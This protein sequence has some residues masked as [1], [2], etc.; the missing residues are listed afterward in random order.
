MSALKPATRSLILAAQMSSRAATR[1]MLAL[2]PPLVVVKLA[3]LLVDRAPR[4]I[5]LSLR[6][7]TLD[8]SP[9]TLL[10]ILLSLVE[11]P[12][13]LLAHVPRP[14]CRVL[15]LFVNVA[16]LLPSPPMLSPRVGIPLPNRRALL[17]KAVVFPRSPVVLALIR[18]VLLVSPVAL[19]PNIDRLSIRLPSFPVS[20]LAFIPR[21][22]AVADSRRALP[23]MELVLL[24]S[25]RKLLP[26]TLSV[27]GM[28]QSPLARAVATLPPIVLPMALPTAGTTLSLKTREVKQPCPRPV[29]HRTRVRRPPA[30][31]EVAETELAKLVGTR[32]LVQHPLP[33]RLLPVLVLS[34]KRKLSELL[35]LKPL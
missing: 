3:V 33:T 16:V 20:P 27:L 8:R 29:I 1:L 21:S 15:E 34:I 12:V 17:P 2:S 4:L 31:P 23:P 10:T 25:R 13:M 35:L 6:L 26:R 14:A 11:V 32:I 24:D 7:A 22:T 9:V 30:P 5:K 28:E 19:V 18:A